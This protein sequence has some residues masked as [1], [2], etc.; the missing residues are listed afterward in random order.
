VTDEPKKKRR[1]RKLVLV[2]TLIA[3]VAGYRSRKLSANDSTY[4][5]A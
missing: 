5:R 3:A 1:G 4:P 2:A